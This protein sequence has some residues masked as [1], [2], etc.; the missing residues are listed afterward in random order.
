MFL[1]KNKNNGKVM[2]IIS[3]VYNS[4]KTSLRGLPAFTFFI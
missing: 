4:F 1:G 3:V 2:T